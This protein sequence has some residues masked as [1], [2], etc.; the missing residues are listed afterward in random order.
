V[1]LDFHAAPPGDWIND[2]NALLFDGTRYRLLVQHRADAPTFMAT[3]WGA[4]ESDDLLRWRWVGS[5][6][7]PGTNRWAYSGSVVDSGAALLAFHTEHDAAAG[8]QMQR[9]RRSQ[10]GGASWDAGDELAIPPL[11]GRRD[12]FVFRWQ[13]GWRMLLARPCAWDHWQDEPPSH[14]EIWASDDLCAWHQVGRIGPWDPPGVLWEV[15]VRISDDGGEGLVLS[16]VDRRGG[17]AVCDT[18]AVPGHFT[19]DGF[20][21]TATAQP[22]DLGP[23]FYAAMTNLAHGWPDPN[24]VVTGWLASWDTARQARWRGFAG[25]P[26]SLPRC[27]AWRNGRA[28]LSALPAVVAGFT[29]PSAIVPKSGMGIA[30]VVGGFHVK[31]SGQDCCLD[32]ISG[33]ASGDVIVCRASENPQFDWSRHHP[34]VLQGS[35]MRTL[36]LFIDGPVVELFIEP[37]AL[38]ISA[39]LPCD[40]PL[41]IKPQFAFNVI[42]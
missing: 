21:V 26:I 4:F 10:D 5:A 31:I 6:I 29:I 14:I 24:T 13:D 18:V 35:G 23:D 30:T 15:P 20:T 22:L 32:I 39:C 9:V 33:H 17:R 25:G 2:P 1:S 19:G 38:V 16:R 8:L 37:D 11:P 12:P 28:A 41:A 40:G 36:R 42:A 27:F 34:G 3:G 7:P